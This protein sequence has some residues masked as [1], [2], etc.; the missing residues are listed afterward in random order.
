MENHE[1]CI[2]CKKCVKVCPHG[3]FTTIDKAK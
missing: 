2:G 3:V 1:S